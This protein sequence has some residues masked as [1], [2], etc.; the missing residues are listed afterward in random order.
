MAAGVP[1]FE[2]GGDVVN[3]LPG[4]EDVAVPQKPLQFLQLLGDVCGQPGC[5]AQSL[6]KLGHHGD[7]H[8]DVEPVEQVL[9]PRIEVT[10]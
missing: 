3:G 7:A 9:G 10:G 1:F 8:G 5:R 6:G 4:T 2:V